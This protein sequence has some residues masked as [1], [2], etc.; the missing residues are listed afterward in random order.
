MATHV[1]ATWGSEWGS[2]GV[3]IAHSEGLEGGPRGSES[4]IWSPSTYVIIYLGFVGFGHLLHHELPAVEGGG[5][6][7][8]GGPVSYTHLT[9]PTILL[10]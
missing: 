4:H 1:S 3:I 8:G 9:L 10:V 5:A 2:E 7:V 6:P